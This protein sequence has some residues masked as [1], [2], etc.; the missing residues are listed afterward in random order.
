[1]NGNFPPDTTP[2]ARQP[3]IFYL[4]DCQIGRISRW[5]FQVFKCSPTV[6]GARG[7]RVRQ[8]SR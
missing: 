2:V 3:N 4:T 1:M 7:P 8:Q 6:S 5:N